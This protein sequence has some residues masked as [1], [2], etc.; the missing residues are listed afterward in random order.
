MSR[1]ETAANSENLRRVGAPWRAAGVAVVLVAALII[2]VGRAQN[3]GLHAP[4]MIAGFAT[5]ALGWVLA[6]VGVY[7]RLRQS[8]R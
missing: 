3:F 6:F 2:V 1:P 4:L 7:L 5:L 8:R